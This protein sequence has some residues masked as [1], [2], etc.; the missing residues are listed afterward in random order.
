MKKFQIFYFVLILFT[1][2]Y[3]SCN[4]TK[5][6]N[7]L[8][9]IETEKLWKQNCALC[10]GSD[11]KLG[12]NGAKDLRLSELSLVPRIEIIKKG[13]GKMIGFE[14]SLSED[15]IKALAKYTFTFK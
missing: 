7:K 10:H 5:K 15:E 13:K 11:G 9:G 6:S 2:V 3:F 1:F 8:D 4:N 14:N 12:L